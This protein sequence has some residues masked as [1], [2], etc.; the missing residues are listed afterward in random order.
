MKKSELNARDI[1]KWMRDHW[2]LYASQLYGK[3]LGKTL[4]LWINGQGRYRVIHGDEI[5]Y[6]GSQMTRAIAAWDTA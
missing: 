1:N 6:E 2:Y 5:L 4:R 3:P